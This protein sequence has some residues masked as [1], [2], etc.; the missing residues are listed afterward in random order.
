MKGKEN[1][2][3]GNFGSSYMIKL[4][5]QTFASLTIL[6][7]TSVCRYQAEE[8]NGEGGGGLFNKLYLVFAAET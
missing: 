7:L 4:S 1:A 3:T 5:F 8:E 2:G 6:F